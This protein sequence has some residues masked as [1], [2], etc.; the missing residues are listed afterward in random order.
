M[1]RRIDLITSTITTVAGLGFPGFNGDGIAA[2]AAA[3]WGPRGVAVDT[4]GNVLIADTFN[5]RV[6]R[7][8][9]GTGIIETIAGDGAGYFDGDGGPAVSAH[10][11]SPAGLAFD[12]NG[13][14]YLADSNNH[15]V[16]RISFT[17]GLIATVAGDGTPGYGGDGGPATSAQLLSPQ[18]VAVDAMGQLLIADTGNHSIRLVAAATGVI[19]PVAGNGVA[20]FSG[21]GGPASASQLNGPKGVTVDE[22]GRLFVA[23]ALNA[24]VRRLSQ[25]DTFIALELFDGMSAV[26]PGDS[27]LYFLTATNNEVTAANGVRFTSDIPAGLE[28]V[29]WVCHASPTFCNGTVPIDQVLDIQPFDMA[30]FFVAGTVAATASDA[31]ELTFR[32]S[33]A[34]DATLA[35]A[36]RSVTDVNAVERLADVRVTKTDGLTSAIPGQAITYTVMVSN[37][38]PGNV[39]EAH[40]TDFLPAGL[41][42]ATWVCNG[43]GAACTGSGTGNIDDFITLAPGTQVTY[44]VSATIAASFSGALSNTASVS[45]AGPVTDPDPSNNSATDL[46][47]VAPPASVQLTDPNGGGV[48]RVANLR[49]IRWTHTLAAGES[50]RVEL[51]RSGPAGP[52]ETLGTA[53]ASAGAFA[54]TVKGPPTPGASAFVRVSWAV[55]PSIADVSD[56]G[57]TIL[58]RVNVVAPNTAV[59]WR[60]GRNET[61]QF[62][63]NVGAGQFVLVELSLNGGSSYVPISIVRTTAPEGTQSL[64][65]RVIAVPTTRARVRVT[66]L[67][68]PPVAPIGHDASDVDFRITW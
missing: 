25:P 30:T 20:G 58:G 23:D 56:A 17:T 1:I 29:S 46:T 12:P 11:S 63:H 37:D 52:W 15:R 34:Y 3:L 67:A 36:S 35:P 64:T 4:S 44:L 54:W 45:F 7:V 33:A 6:R 22:R 28:D 5:E 19:H 62:G 21:D 2:T 60:I 26:S 47:H 31:I 57:F 59:T 40:V 27:Y 8:D 41:E 9:A 42:G 38:G 53:P 51:S 39:R 65:W 48:W 68:L 13:D 43:S 16:R 61:I 55:D 18:A 50:V 66:W 49:E 32:L 24:R 10:V 14:L